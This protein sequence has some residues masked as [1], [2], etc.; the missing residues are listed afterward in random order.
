MNLA[1][2]LP[3]LKPAGLDRIN[4]SLDSLVPAKF[5]FI[6]RR[7]GEG[8]VVLISPCIYMFNIKCIQCVKSIW[9]FSFSPGFHKVMEGINKAIEMGYNPVKVSQSLYFDITTLQKML[10]IIIHNVNFTDLV[11][12]EELFY[13]KTIQLHEKSNAAHKLYL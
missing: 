5:E 6:V 3:R 11:N 9:F 12:G 8:T 1:K 13:G 2:L 4:I 10:N 7:K